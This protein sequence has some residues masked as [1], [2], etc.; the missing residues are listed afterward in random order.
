MSLSVAAEAFMIDKPT[1]LYD[2]PERYEN[3]QQKYGIM[4]ELHHTIP[5]KYLSY[6]RKHESLVKEVCS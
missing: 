4:A 3:G 6:L 1:F 5:E 2:S